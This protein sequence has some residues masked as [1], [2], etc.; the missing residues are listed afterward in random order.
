MSHEGGIPQRP[1]IPETPGF[2][3]A[4]NHDLTAREDDTPHR[5]LAAAARSVYLDDDHAQPRRPRPHPY[6]SAIKQDE[7]FINQATYVAAARRSMV[8]AAVA[9]HLFGLSPRQTYTV[10]VASKTQ[11]IR[12][13]FNV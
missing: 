3:M 8:N 5:S 2:L 1:T 7:N 9:R 4:A 6:E 12:G 10:T 13:S 11:W